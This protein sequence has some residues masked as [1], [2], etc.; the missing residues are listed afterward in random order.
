VDY[1]DVG[2]SALNL[3]TPGQVAAVLQCHEKTVR[4]L[5]SKGELKAVKVGS[6][7]RI[8]PADLASYIDQLREK[9]AKPLAPC[10]VRPARYGEAWSTSGSAG[11]GNHGVQ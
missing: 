6:L 4:R 1:Q 11:S 8:V 10:S 2:V 5:I 7:L 9:G 3:L